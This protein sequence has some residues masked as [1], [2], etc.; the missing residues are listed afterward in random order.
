MRLKDKVA[1]ITGG[2]GGMGLSTAMRFLAEGAR[3]VIA[4]FNTANG[5]AA[6]AQAR[7]QGLGEAARFIRTDVAR[8]ADVK[9]MIECAMDEFGRLD[10]IFN[11]AGVGGAIGPVWELEEE[12]WDYTFDVLVKGVFF[13]IKHGTRA[14]RQQQQGGSIINTASIAGISGGCGPLA[15]SAAKAAVINLSKAAAGQLAPDRI[16]VNAICPGF[17]LT[18]LTRSERQTLEEAGRHLDGM[19]PW[20]DHGKGDDIAGTALFLASDDAR[21]VSGEAI[22]V[23]GALTAIGPDL[24]QRF[25]IPREAQMEKA[26]INRGTTG[27]GNRT[28]TLKGE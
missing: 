7:E 9:A 23:D 1:V 12:E 21:F 16:R 22:V 15:Y 20:P 26:R 4:D 13:G 14:L 8:E 18:G 11:N 19:Q 28:R 24:W 25:G 17:I 6:L 27:E 5:E 2:A 3:V 10:I